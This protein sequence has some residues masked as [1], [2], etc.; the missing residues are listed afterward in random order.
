MLAGTTSITFGVSG[1]VSDNIANR[2][3]T[4][5]CTRSTVDP[6]IPSMTPNIAV[7][8][9]DMSDAFAAIAGG[10]FEVGKLAQFPVQRS[11]ANHLLC[12]GREVARSSFPELFDYLR[13]T[14]GAAADPLNFKLPNFLGTITP[15]AVAQTETA[16]L[17]TVSTPPP[18]GF[19]PDEPANNYGDADSG[20]RSRT[21][22]V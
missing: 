10:F 6:F 22:L 3:Y 5:I 18:V 14:Q 9:R 19:P 13:N 7:L 1:A 20:G 21:A 12:D 2:I 11:V 15:A 8:S 16:T 17:G 4:Y